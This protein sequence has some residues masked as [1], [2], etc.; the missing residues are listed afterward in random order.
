MK[1]RITLTYNSSLAT[2]GTGAQLQRIFA[3]YALSK[4]LHIPYLSS[5][6]QNLT[7]TQLDPFQDELSLEL[8]LGRVNKEFYLPSSLELP[9]SFDF[10]CNVD[11]LTLKKLFTLYFK[12]LLTN[13]YFL[14]SV[15]NPYN[16][17]EK[18]PT[19]YRHLQSFFRTDNSRSALNTNQKTIVIHIRWGSSATDIVSGE[20]SI[21]SLPNSYYHSLL[22]QIKENY[23]N[24]NQ[25]LELI[26]LTDAPEKT[27]RYHPIKSQLKYWKNEKRFHDG[28]ID[29]FGKNFDEFN[30]DSL[31]K[32]TIIRGGDPVLALQLMKEADFLVMSRSS[33]SY[34][35]AILNSQG[36]IFYPPN[37][38]HQPMKNWIRVK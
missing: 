11:R 15:L 30:L 1:P 16:I 2:D 31:H 26:L 32:F 13:K 19:S 27:L 28:G 34:V 14:L 37:F 38:W 25:E 22:S 7:I 10:I 23:C 17:V 35:G 33:F 4:T 24:A 29:I 18:F 21:R 5:K 3:I 8:Y 12:A 6:I 36:K 9:N 20:S